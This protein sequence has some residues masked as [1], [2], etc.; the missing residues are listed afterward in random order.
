MNLRPAAGRQVNLTAEGGAV[1]PPLRAA[2]D[3]WIE[4]GRLSY[5]MLTRAAHAGGMHTFTAAMGARFRQRLPDPGDPGALYERFARAFY[6]TFVDSLAPAGNTGGGTG[7]GAGAGPFLGSVAGPAE[8]PGAGGTET[9]AEEHLR[10]VSVITVAMATRACRRFNFQLTH[11]ATV[12]VIE[13]ALFER[14]WVPLKLM[15]M[16]HTFALGE[17][18]GVGGGRPFLA[19]VLRRPADSLAPAEDWALPAMDGAEPLGELWQL[20][21]VTVVAEARAR[22]HE[23]SMDLPEGSTVLDLERLCRTRRLAEVHLVLVVAALTRA[24]ETPAPARD[25]SRSPRRWQ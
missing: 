22:V 1:P 16:T 3:T 25:R 23:E 10:F 14:R 20:R 12:L 18:P 8:G 17:N 21:R 19:P 2:Y 7:S 4:E 24:P 15:L 13:Q 6:M 11:D 5:A 9:I